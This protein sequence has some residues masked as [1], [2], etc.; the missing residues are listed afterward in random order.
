M[1]DLQSRNCNDV[2]VSAAPSATRQ[3]AAKSTGKR[4]LVA[5]DAP[6]DSGTSTEN[7]NPIAINSHR[8]RFRRITGPR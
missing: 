4:D 8:V 7:E 5:E 6:A 3:R 1:A 2:D